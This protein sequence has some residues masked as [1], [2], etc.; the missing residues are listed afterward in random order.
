[1]DLASRYG[2]WNTITCIA[3]LRQDRIEAPWPLD[4]PINAERFR[5]Y[6]EQ[7][8]V[9]TLRPAD[10]VIADNFGSHKSVAVRKAIRDAGAKL[11]LLPKYSP[12]LNPIEQ[13]FNQI[14]HLLRNAA[15]RSHKPSARPSDRSS[16]PSPRTNAQ[17]TSETRHTRNLIPSRSG[18][19][20][21]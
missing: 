4:G 1:V 10:L 8:L 11:L 5:L 6:V 12:D 2:H 20:F 21:A 16:R 9:P 7:G 14:E 13:V 18:A 19:F 17:T 3:A 15:A